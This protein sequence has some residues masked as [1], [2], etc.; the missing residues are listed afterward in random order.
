MSRVSERRRVG[1][2][3]P[4]GVGGSARNAVE[5]PGPYG[6]PGASL[7]RLQLG[8]D[9]VSLVAAVSAEGAD[10]AQFACVCPPGHRFGVN[11]I[12]FRDFGGGE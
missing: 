9:F 6:G 7:L 11:T 10:A 3:H 4:P 2:S 5:A 12:G 1:C 8:F